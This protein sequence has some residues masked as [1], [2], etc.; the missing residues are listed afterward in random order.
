MGLI[1]YFCSLSK[2]MWYKRDIRVKMYI[3]VDLHT[4]V[5]FYTKG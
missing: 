2:A 5:A 4:V 1:K 3:D